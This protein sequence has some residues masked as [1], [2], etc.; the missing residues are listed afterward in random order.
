MA[1]EFSCT[2]PHKPLPRKTRRLPKRLL[3]IVIRETRKSVRAVYCNAYYARPLECMAR[4]FP[5]LGEA[6]G[7]ETFAVFCSGYLQV[8]PSSSYMLSDHRGD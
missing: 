3:R 7:D 6:V 1:E 8:C 5:A 4:E 2:G